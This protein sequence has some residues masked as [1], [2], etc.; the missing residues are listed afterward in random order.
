MKTEDELD[1]EIAAMFDE[2]KAVKVEMV[3]GKPK[4]TDEQMVVGDAKEMETVAAY[5]VQ[6]FREFTA[7]MDRGVDPL[8]PLR[9][10]EWWSAL[11]FLSFAENR[12]K[13]CFL[14]GHRD[15]ASVR[16]WAEFRSGILGCKQRSRTDA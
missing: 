10:R 15:P 13:D 9:S 4:I 3:N 14:A 11:G 5:L 16:R 2:V 12:A 6:A 1:A 8:D 7:T